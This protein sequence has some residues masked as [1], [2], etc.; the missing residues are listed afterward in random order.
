MKQLK[1]DL[2]IN[3]CKAINFLRA[4]VV[5]MPILYLSGCSNDIE[6]IN[7]L[8]AGLD[9]PNQSGKNIEVQYSDSARL[10]LIFKAPV[11]ERYLDR[12]EEGPYYEFPE[13]IE[14]YFYDNNEELESTIKAGYAKYLEEKNL[15]KASDS[16]VA[17]NVKTLEQLN[18]EELFWNEKDKRVYS[19]VFTKIT[20]NDGV[21]YGQ[22]GFESDQDLNNYVLK[23]SSGTVDVEDEEFE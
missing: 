13:G 18:T 3:N 16:V 22:D 9:I 19:H 15:W 17:R 14:V 6:R 12:G 7:E 5:L 4:L 8:T 11:M 10:Q 1:R 20:N 21:F 23:G 2:T